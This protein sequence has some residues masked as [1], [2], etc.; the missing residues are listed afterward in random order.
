MGNEAN[1]KALYSMLSKLLDHKID[2]LQ[3]IA[4]KMPSEVIKDPKNTVNL[5]VNKVAAKL[6]TALDTD[7]QDDY[8]QKMLKTPQQT[9]ISKIE[10]EV[11][12]FFFF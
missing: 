2:N 7:I 9:L 8:Y 1:I 5:A 3:K 11:W 6:I 4:Q 12:I 10:T